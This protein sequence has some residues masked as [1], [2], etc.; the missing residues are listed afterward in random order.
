MR[1]LIKNL[2]ERIFGISVGTVYI[3]ERRGKPVMMH[4]RDW[5]RES[6]LDLLEENGI[7]A[8]FYVPSAYAKTQELANALRLLAARGY[9]MTDQEGNLVGAV[10][11][12]RPTVDEVAQQRRAEFKVLDGSN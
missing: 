11:T 5:E 4:E 2:Y 10:A 8:Q 9:I 12:A 7:R 6:A 1:Q 3:G